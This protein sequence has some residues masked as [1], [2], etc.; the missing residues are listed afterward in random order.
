VRPVVGA[1]G[2]GLRVGL[3]YDGLR[4][5]LLGRGEDL[6][7]RLPIPA[8]ACVVVFRRLYNSDRSVSFRCRASFA[9]HL[10]SRWCVNHLRREPPV[11]PQ[12]RYRHRNRRRGHGDVPSDG[13]LDFSEGDQS[14]RFDRDARGVVVDRVRECWQLVRCERPLCWRGFLSGVGACN[15]LHRRVGHG[16]G[17]KESVGAYLAHFF[18]QWSVVQYGIL[19]TRRSPRLPF[20]A[21]A[22]PSPS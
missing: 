17:R 11:S 18:P 12:D 2:I 20:S 19:S 14:G 6:V 16:R 5:V 15:G 3:V 22:S 9:A 7:D 4:V 13:S 1:G 8:D 21:C 10:W